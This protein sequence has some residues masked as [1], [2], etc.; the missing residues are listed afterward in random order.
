MGMPRA[1]T[2]SSAGP[3]TG[4]ALGSAWKRRCSGSRVLAQALRA[5]RERGHAGLRAVVGQGAGQ[6]VARAALRAVDEGVAV[7][8]VGGVE[9]L[10][11]AVVAGG[12]VG[13][14]RVRHLAR[15]A[16]Q[17]AK[18]RLAGERPCT[19]RLQMLDAGERRRVGLQP[20]FESCERGRRTLDL[21]RDALCVVEDPPARP[22]SCA[23]RKTNGRNPTPCTAPRTRIARRST[24]ASARAPIA[25]RVRA[26]ATARSALR[27]RP[28]GVAARPP[29]RAAAGAR[30]ARHA[31]SRPARRPCRR[32]WS[33][34]PGRS[35]SPG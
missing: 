2:S 8:P 20:S 3:Q 21:D 14:D 6:R 4:Q 17:D 5:L 23:R 24:A 16:G 13:R 31:R 7:A 19:R 12:G 11:Q 25:A 18:A 30:R 34:R 28:R 32:R 33:P 29:C 26:T 22:S 9:Q 27:A 10:G 35:R 1:S 15:P